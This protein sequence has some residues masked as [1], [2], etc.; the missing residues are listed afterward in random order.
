MGARILFVGGSLNQTTMMHSIAERLPE[1]RHAFSPLY[2]DGLIQRLAD[3]GR[4]DFTTLGGPSRR[5]S[6]NYLTARGLTIDDGGRRGPYDLAVMGTDL[7]VPRNLRGRPLVLVQEG[8]TDPEDWR[9]RLVRAL[10][11]P[12]YLANTSMTG[13]SHAYERFCVASEGYRE[14]FVRKGV[15]EERIAVTGI[16]NFDDAESLRTN[17]FPFRG[18]VLAATVCLRET[19][20][21][22]NRTAFIRKCLRIAAGRPLLFKLHPNEDAGRATREIAALAPQAAVFAEG[23]TGHMIAN[24]D[25]LVTRYSSVVYIALALGKEVHADMDLEMLR[26]LMP[27]Q[28][29]GRS[30]ERI[31]DVCRRSLR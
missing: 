11:L 27:I 28:N 23:N 20:K 6:L 10:R 30:A 21:P 13:L 8:M 24:C 26:A 31:A 18:Y 7:I 16:P 3:R 25:V 12:R 4:L 1:H 2:G 14:L 5:R 15:R 29:G 22:E 17:D 9:Y 19:L